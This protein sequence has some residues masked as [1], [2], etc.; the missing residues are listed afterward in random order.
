M[1]DFYVNKLGLEL[2]EEF[3]SFFAVKAGN[4]KFSFGGGYKKNAKDNDTVSI[5]LLL[6][7]D[8]IVKTRDTLIEKGINLV[9]EITDEGGYKYITIKDPDGNLIHIGG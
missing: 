3:D 5:V 1:K 6:S 7:T 2:I 8:N 4:V 9:S